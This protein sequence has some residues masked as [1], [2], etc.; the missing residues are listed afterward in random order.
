MSTMVRA[1]D[2][3]PSQD[4]QRQ[5]EMAA[6]RARLAELHKTAGHAEKD[7][8]RRFRD[9]DE[10][11]KEDERRREELLNFRPGNK[12]ERDRAGA[13]V[14]DQAQTEL[15]AVL[16]N[17]DRHDTI[18]SSEHQVAVEELDH[19][20][21]DT[22][23]ARDV[24]TDMVTAQSVNQ[25][26]VLD[27]E[28]GKDTTKPPNPHDFDE[29]LIDPRLV[30]MPEEKFT[31][32]TRKKAEWVSRKKVPNPETVLVDGWHDGKGPEPD[33]AVKAVEKAGDP[34]ALG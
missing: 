2:E 17:A 32:R 33:A 4:A 21:V 6:G 34:E 24:T 22:G 25:P 19:P 31:P 28:A 13:E 3:S 8:H 10:E 12:E 30:T 14:A 5:A 20:D 29:S 18:I 1:R 7:L 23:L 16:H 15:E 27:S 9:A 11:I 26:V